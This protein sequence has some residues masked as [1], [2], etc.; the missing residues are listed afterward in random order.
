[1]PT[2]TGVRTLEQ[3]WPPFALQ[4]TAGPLQLTAVRDRDIPALV[5]LAEDGIHDPAAMPFSPPWSA[6][7]ADALGRA[8]AAYYW[9]V[10][11]GFGPDRWALELVARWD[12]V[13]VGVQ[14]FSTVDYLV[15]RTGET[16]SWLGRAHQGRGIGTAMR[17]AICAFV[18]DHLDAEEVTSAAFV[19]NPASL[20]V[21]RKLG[22]ADNG[23]FR[24]KR[25]DGELAMSRE[26]TLK[27]EALV[28]SRHPTTVRGVEGLRRFV[29]LNDQ[30]GR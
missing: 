12:G 14:A 25:R 11:A 15:T 2:L 23:V 27:P 4:V 29:G 30:A 10:R 7:P 1:M 26:L 18:F 16:G 24:R 13:V 3:I 9:G 6:A 19:D 5:S 22:Y 28:R 20:A 8:M 17:Q 21:S